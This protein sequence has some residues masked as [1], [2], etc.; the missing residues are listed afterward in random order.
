MTHFMFFCFSASLIHITTRCRYDVGA[1]S[2]FG[3]STVTG[4]WV[5]HGYLCFC[6]YFRAPQRSFSIHYSSNLSF[7][8]VD[9]S[10]PNAVFGL[11]VI[12]ALFSRSVFSAF[13]VCRC[14]R[15]YSQPCTWVNPRRKVG[16]PAW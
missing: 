16:P 13:S 2:S 14:F 5:V 8:V 4:V 9:C 7:G 12:S 3:L 15:H 10:L 6:S 11:P 1:W